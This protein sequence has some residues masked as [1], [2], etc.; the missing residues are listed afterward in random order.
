MKHLANI[1]IAGSIIYLGSEARRPIT[2][3]GA[4]ELVGCI[5]PAPGPCVIC[6][7]G[8]AMA[9]LAFQGSLQSVVIHASPVRL[10]AAAWSHVRVLPEGSGVGRGDQELMD[11]VGAARIRFNVPAR[12][13]HVGYLERGIR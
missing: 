8:Q 4:I 11:H 9:K 3:R 10:D 6:Q 13:P 1:R 7:E 12:R 2:Y 5:R